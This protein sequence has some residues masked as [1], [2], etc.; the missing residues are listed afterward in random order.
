MRPENKG[1]SMNDTLTWHS[2]FYNQY[3]SSKQHAQPFMP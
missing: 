1:A 3:V 2:Y